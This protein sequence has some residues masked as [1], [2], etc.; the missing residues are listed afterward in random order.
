MATIH[1][2]K[3]QTVD[4]NGDPLSGGKLYTYEVGTTTD[5]ATY[6]DAA[7]TN[8]HANPV[9]LDSLGENEIHGS[10]FYKFVLKASDDTEIWT[11]AKYLAGDEVDWVSISDYSNSLNTAVSE[12]GATNKTLVI[13]KAITIGANVTVP[14]TLHLLVLNV[15]NGALQ[16]SN[17]ITVTY[18]CP[19]TAG[20][21]QIFGGNG[22]HTITGIV[23][24]V[25]K[26]WTS[27]GD[28]A[29]SYSA[30]I[31]RERAAAPT[32]LA[33]EMGAYAKVIDGQSEAFINEESAG[34][35][36]QVTS[37]GKLLFPRGWIAGLKLSNDTD[38]D[39]DINVTAGE[40]DDSTHAHNIILAAEMT[41]QIDATW[42]AG[43]DA[44]GMNDGEAVGN[45]TWYHVHLLMGGNTVD[46]GFDTSITAANLLAD[47]AVIAAGLTLYRRIGSVLTDG[48]ANILAFVQVGDDFMWKDPPLDINTETVTATQETQAISTPLGIATKA[49]CL[50]LEAT[51]GN[52][53]YIPMHPDVN[54]EAP[55]DT[56]APLHNISHENSAISASV[57]QIW[58]DTSSQIKI[59]SDA[60]NSVLELVT[61][62]YMDRR[63]QDD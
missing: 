59:R 62:G 28:D 37:K 38:T 17:G 51:T 10:G 22:T 24:E 25:N 19:I 56:V 7:L 41:K 8:A 6:S 1:Y 13:D 44:G 47:A 23:G 60:A 18:N 11:V 14:A 63:G 16:P 15:T 45:T 32:T 27:G 12:I 53:M 21:Y 30:V 31:I 29:N 57:L 39:H 9:V 26:K 52:R 36:I 46:I 58:T 40:A 49:Y 61:Q 3:F 43:N 2:P 35:E 20:G 4:S 33:N 34:G 50:A 54:D 42:A 48:T 5:K 55:S